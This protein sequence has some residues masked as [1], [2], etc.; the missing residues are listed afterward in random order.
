MRPMNTI[1]IHSI[2]MQQNKIFATNF[3]TKTIVI[4]AMFTQRYTYCV[5]LTKN[6]WKMYWILTSNKQPNET[7]TEQKLIRIQIKCHP[8]VSTIC[9]HVRTCQNG[10]PMLLSHRRQRMCMKIHRKDISIKGFIVDSVCF[11][12]SVRNC[13]CCFLLAVETETNIQIMIFKSLNFSEK[14]MNFNYLM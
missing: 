8:N 5:T 13:S 3:F 9:C 12:F 11:E 4:N 2:Q 10:F 7:C 14:Q 1:P 6:I